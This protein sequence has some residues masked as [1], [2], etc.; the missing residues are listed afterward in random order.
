MRS[1][2]SCSIST[3]A[4]AISRFSVAILLFTATAGAATEGSE[5]RSPD[6]LPPGPVP[7]GTPDPSQA[8]C[9]WTRTA[10]DCRDAD[11]VKKMLITSS[12]IHG[13]VGLYGIWLLYYRN[14][15]FSRKIVTEL[16]TFAG[17]GIRPKPMDCILF[18]VSIACFVKIGANMPLLF[19][20]LR[21]SWW[22]RIAIEQTYWVFVSFAFASYKVGL[23]YAMPV[24][25]REGIFA[26]YQPETSY[27]TKPLPSIHVLAP[28]T[29]QRNIMLA[30]GATYPAIFG[31]GLGIASGVMHDRGN[32][33]MAY[34]LLLAQYSNWVLILWSMAVMF[35]Y[36]G[37]KYTFILRA[38]II[39]AE[40][41]LKAPRAAFGI[42][43]LKSRSPARFLFIQLQITGFGGCAVTLLAGA[44]CLLWVLF[45]DKILSVHDDRWPHAMLFFWTGAIAVAFFV[46]MVLITAQSIRS[47]KRG[48]HNLS[49]TASNVPSSGRNEQATAD[50]EARDVN[51]QNISS[52][53]SKITPSR[54]DA[55]ACLT[56]ASSGDVSTL[57]SVHSSE[58]H[59]MEQV[60][61]IYDHDLEAGEALEG[62]SDR[63]SYM[64]TS[65]TP[66]PRPQLLNSSP[67][68][69]NQVNL[70]ES[71]FG[72]RTPR[73]DRSTISPPSSP[74]SGPTSLGGFNLPSFP[75][76]L[77]SGSRNSVT[78]R[79]ST[80][81]VI[82]YAA[83]STPGSSATNS[84]HTTSISTMNTNSTGGSTNR[85]SGF[86]L[87]QQPSAGPST[88]PTNVSFTRASTLGQQPTSPPPVFHHSYSLQ[89]KQQQQQQQFRQWSQPIPPPPPRQ[90]PARRQNSVGSPPKN[91]GSPPKNASS[92][93]SAP[94]TI[95][96]SRGAGGGYRGQGIEMEAIQQQDPLG[97]EIIENEWP[98]PPTFAK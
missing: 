9:D 42:G 47:R 77:R 98:L 92:S 57:H 71:V 72:G 38:N 30:I 95:P 64:A 76:T 66:P 79:P 13:F 44:L 26:V 10:A 17:S 93:L 88:S 37:L 58:K 51:G 8:L 21:D 32:A 25:T 61:D 5:E 84:H 19:D 54:S 12:A 83:G 6:Y 18:F 78:P 40:T 41:E 56:H 2:G 70:R 14:R 22:I 46:L 87:L 15:G 45:H 89:P 34:I 60:H 97:A 33:R 16:F 74:P 29:F 23:L 28:T 43:N 55:E 31:G 82:G 96:A 69:P 52:R 49:S 75:R 39:I 85:M 81:S 24:T 63:A 65:L 73:D 67:A 48:L 20:V 59:S 86:S 36:Y 80:S 4:T 50:A 68:A 53:G 3:L 11:F 1:F 35:F 90:H 94:I 91:G 27:G 7:E 62:D